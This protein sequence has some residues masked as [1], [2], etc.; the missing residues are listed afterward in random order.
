MKRF[1]R[2]ET[3]L[4]IVIWLVLMIGGRSK[5]FQDP[6]RPTATPYYCANNG[7]LISLANFPDSML[8]LP[9][10]SSKDAVDL[11]FEIQT[12]R[13][14]PLRTP[15]LVTLEPVVPHKK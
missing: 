14:P 9:V 5:F 10:K 11:L 6:E 7:E 2:P 8:D 12:P 1:V 15:V 13:I 4:F 3:I